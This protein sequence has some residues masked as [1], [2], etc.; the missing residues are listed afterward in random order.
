MA[1]STKSTEIAEKEVNL[2][3]RKIKVYL[4][5]IEYPNYFAIKPYAQFID[6]KSNSN[7]KV[8][9]DKK[10]KTISI[11]SKIIGEETIKALRKLLDETP[12]EDCI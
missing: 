12:I 9:F 1:S 6:G 11:G 5:K 3:G 7:P 2:E 4:M 10:S 8:G